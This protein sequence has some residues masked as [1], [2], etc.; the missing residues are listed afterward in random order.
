MNLE[1]NKKYLTVQDI[2]ERTEGN[3]V[4]Q[5][6]NWIKQERISI[7]AKDIIT[8]EVQPAPSGYMLQAICDANPG[9]IRVLESD[10]DKWAEAQQQQDQIPSSSTEQENSPKNSDFYSIGK[11]ITEGK[12]VSDILEIIH[13]CGAC[14]FEKTGRVTCFL[15][16]DNNLYDL[17]I[18]RLDDYL[19]NFIHANYSQGHKRKSEELLNELNVTVQTPVH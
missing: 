8:G 16:G 6:I 11:M 3:T 1:T 12:S 10:F 18:S 7:Y 13:K 14:W 2:A 15:Y 5:V 17:V 9:H 4:Q 19:I